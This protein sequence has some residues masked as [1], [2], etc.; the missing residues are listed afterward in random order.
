M[1]RSAWCLVLLSLVGDEP[2]PGWR[3]RG[4][5]VLPT[6]RGASVRVAVDPLYQER[7]GTQLLAECYLVRIGG[8]MH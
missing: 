1:V 8:R 5:M 3:S 7:L 6:G 2:W 4:R